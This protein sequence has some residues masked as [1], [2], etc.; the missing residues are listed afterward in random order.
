MLGEFHA[1]L[2]FWL[3]QEAHFP[4]K[5]RRTAHRLYECLQVDGYCGSYTAYVEETKRVSHLCLIRIDR[6]RYSVPAHWANAVI[7]VR[8]TADCVRI[9]AEG[10][11][12]AEHPRCFSR[13]QLICDP[14][15]YLPILE[16]KSQVP[17]GMVR[18][19]RLGICLFPLR[20]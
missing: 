20:Q 10:Q 7:S 17:S 18:R 6:N 13:D 2:D 15:H 9:V 14:W 16:K 19:F 12:I 4:R 1:A 5:Q 3:E 11:M 8:L